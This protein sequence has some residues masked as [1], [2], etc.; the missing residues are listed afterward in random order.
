MYAPWCGLWGR[1][2]IRR[3]CCVRTGPRSSWLM[4]GTVLFVAYARV[5]CMTGVSVVTVRLLNSES[6]NSGPGLHC[7]VL[8]FDTMICT[9]LHLVVVVRRWL[10]R[11]ESHFAHCNKL[12]HNITTCKNR[13][14]VSAF[15]R[16]N[17]NRV[18][19]FRRAFRPVAVETAATHPKW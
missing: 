4:V 3:R 19:S 13:T 12:V 2:H 14:S 16:I 10:L 7:S 9:H 8:C 17:V 15:V 18:D 1:G 6:L 11:D 5:S